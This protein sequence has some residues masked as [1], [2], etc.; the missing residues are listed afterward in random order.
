MRRLRKR[1]SWVLRQFEYPMV[2]QLFVTGSLIFHLYKFDYLDISA[3]AKG[4]LISEC[5]S[6]VKTSSKNPT[7]FLPYFCPSLF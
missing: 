2:S 5:P 4:Q 6:G 3:E 1:V 7:K